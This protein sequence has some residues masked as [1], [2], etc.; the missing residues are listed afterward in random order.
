MTSEKK[1]KKPKIRIFN[2]KFLYLIS[3][4]AKCILT[5]N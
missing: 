4:P 3:I 2:S 5:D 1:I